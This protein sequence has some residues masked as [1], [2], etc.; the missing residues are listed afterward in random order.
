MYVI[1]GASGKVGGASA[2]ALR[3]AGHAVRA[4]V[5][6]QVQAEALARI[7]C[8]VALAALDDEAAIHRALDGARAVQ[9][10]CPVADRA[11]DAQAAMRRMIHTAAKAL[12]AHPGLHVLALSDYGAELEGGTGITM[13]YRELEQA[14]RQAAPRLTLLRA[15]EHMQNWA[16]V[17]PVALA[18]GHLPTLHHPADM[19]FPTVSAHD[20]GTLAAQLL[21]EDP[22]GVRVVSIE[23][24]RRY[25]ADEAAALLGEISGRA[26]HAHALPREAWAATLA[27]AGLNAGLAQLVMEINDAQ[28]A[29]R[30]GA[31]PDSE[32]RFGETGL[33][34]VLAGLVAATAAPQA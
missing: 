11:A 34:E 8:D 22:A 28:N 30:I 27:R 7:G 16:R 9:L 21:L 15:A 17:L 32:R 1:F 24:A 13:L 19:P 5:R 20:V 33:R 31:A 3:R 10:L 14:Y 12:H 25:S 29:G 26:I 23:A 18:T 4:V 2:A 6:D